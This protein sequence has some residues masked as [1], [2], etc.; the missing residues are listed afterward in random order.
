[1]LLQ[2]ALLCTDQD[3]ESKTMTLRPVARCICGHGEVPGGN[4]IDYEEG[5]QT[6]AVG[7]GLGRIVALHYCSSTLYHIRSQVRCIFFLKRQ[8]D[9]TPGGHRRAQHR[10]P[11]RSTARSRDRLHR[12]T[13][14]R[15]AWA[16][17]NTGQYLT[18][19]AQCSASTA[20]GRR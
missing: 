1:M 12:D 13:A 2:A 17:V 8:C 16:R 11:P 15:G 20:A 5:V 4:M 18:L 10:A 3:H 6:E 7:I 19:V 9:R 14:W